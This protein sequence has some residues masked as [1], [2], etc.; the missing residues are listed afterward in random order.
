MNFDII[1]LIASCIFWV[2]MTV[3]FAF[4]VDDTVMKIVGMTAVCFEL[5][6]C[7]AGRYIAFRRLE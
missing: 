6:N 1:D 4:F 3:W 5:V 7:L 2:F